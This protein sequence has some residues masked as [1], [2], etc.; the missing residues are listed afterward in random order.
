MERSRGPYGLVH[1]NPSTEV[2]EDEQGDPGEAGKEGGLPS[3]AKERT[4]A[5]V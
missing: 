1:T 4:R 5:T 2:E 3:P